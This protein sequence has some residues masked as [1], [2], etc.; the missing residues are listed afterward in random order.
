MRTTVFLI[1]S[2]LTLVSCDQNLVDSQ[3]IAFSDAQ[4]PLLEAPVFKIQ[5][6]DTVNTYD[7]FLHMRNNHDYAYSNLYLI[8]EISFRR[9]SI[10]YR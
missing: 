9:L 4:W 8:A 6:V 5:P 1:L 3:S 7:M 2:C 10:S